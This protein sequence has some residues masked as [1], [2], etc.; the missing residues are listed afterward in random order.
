MFHFVPFTVIG[1]PDYDQSLE[2][3]K[4]YIENGATMLEL[5]LPFSDP[6]ADGPTVQLADQRALKAGMNTDDAFKFI[7]EV[8]SLTDMPINLLLYFN[9]VFKYGMEK[10]YEQAA[11]AGVTS[12]L[13]ADL[14]LDTPH[15]QE[16]LELS[17]KHGVKS[18]FI[19]SELT[20]DDRL[21]HIIE[22]DPFFLYFVSTPGVTGERKDLS[23]LL[24]DTIAHIKSK[25]DIPVLVGFGVS[26][27]E[28]V[29]KIS[30][31]GADGVIVGSAL[32]KLIEEKTLGEIPG[33]MK[34]MIV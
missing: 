28:H 30:T 12:L 9:L 4:A 27:R 8:R 24:A 14:P 5:G 26:D 18:V 11:E 34:S 13:I 31:A 32:V 2:V 22:S 23:E 21:Q 3:V 15:G 17:K 10:F 25:T 29:Q 1:D 19:V 33:K 7:K 6:V 16:A 20:P